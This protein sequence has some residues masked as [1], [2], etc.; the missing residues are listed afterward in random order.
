VLDQ[1]A[2]AV[3][4]PSDAYTYEQKD[5]TT[6]VGVTCTDANAAPRDNRKLERR[7][8]G[9]CYTNTSV[10]KDVA[11]IGPVSVDVG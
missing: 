3:D 2:P 8:D 5:P 9:L 6:S 1:K 7:S 11:I 4:S 10:K